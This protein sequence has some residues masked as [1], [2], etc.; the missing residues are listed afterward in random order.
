MDL[1]R[2]SLEREVR[3]LESR[4][5]EAQEE[6][7]TLAVGAKSKDGLI[8]L[9]VGNPGRVHELTLDPRVKRLD[10]EDL[11]GRIV[12]MMNDALELLRHETADKMS[13]IL[14]DFPVNEPFGDERE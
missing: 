11:A 2:E 12:E 7:E 1:D 5:R 14:P 4:T 9:T 13:A 6:I 8:E 10:V 3:A